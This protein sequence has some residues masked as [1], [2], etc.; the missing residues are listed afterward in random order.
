MVIFH[1]YVTV[2]Q[3]VVVVFEGVKPWNHEIGHIRILVILTDQHSDYSDNEL[4]TIV[5]QDESWWVGLGAIDDMGCFFWS[6]LEACVASFKGAT[7]QRP[8]G[9]IVGPQ[10]NGKVIDHC[11]NGISINYYDQLL[12]Y[13]YCSINYSWG[14]LQSETV[15][16]NLSLQ[17]PC[18]N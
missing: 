14:W 13:Y 17:H 6:G 18:L 15:K 11:L 3:R 4:I 10:K 1:S 2:Y 5:N 9:G 12:W 8:R 7:E 16:R